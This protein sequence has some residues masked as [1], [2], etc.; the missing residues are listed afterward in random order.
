MIQHLTCPISL[1]NIKV[2][3]DTPTR[4]RHAAKTPH[5]MARPFTLPCHKPDLFIGL[6]WWAPPI[7]CA[8]RSTCATKCR[9]RASENGHKFR[10]STI[11]HKA[12]ESGAQKE[13]TDDFLPNW[14]WKLSGI[15]PKRPQ[16]EAES[17]LYIQV[18]LL[19][20]WIPQSSPDSPSLLPIGFARP[21][22]FICQ[23]R[24]TGVWYTK[25]C[26]GNQWL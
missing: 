19:R 1:L 14:V 13:L 8:Y 24:T 25:Y 15:V 26:D 11:Y 6:S 10:I 7:S 23:T 2:F 17:P 9:T 21:S 12:R 4:P 16:P 3:H 20:T 22:S 5:N 18:L